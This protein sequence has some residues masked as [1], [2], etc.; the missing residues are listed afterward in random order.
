MARARQT[1]VHANWLDRDVRTLSRWLSCDVRAPAGPDL[2]TRQVLFD[3]IA[4]ELERLE[5]EDGR[6]IRPV[7]VALCNQRDDLLA[8]AGVLD[9]KLAGIAQTLEIPLS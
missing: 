1:E 3:F 9:N 7:R 2:A 4:D 8:F 5:P 6:R